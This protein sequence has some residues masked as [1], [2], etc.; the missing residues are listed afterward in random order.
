[1]GIDLYFLLAIIFLV[2]IGA[3]IGAGILIYN[4]RKRN[5]AKNDG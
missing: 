5:E 3:V 2:G 1:M 4:I